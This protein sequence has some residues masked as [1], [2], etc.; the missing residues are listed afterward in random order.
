MHDRTV[1]FVVL[2]II[3][4]GAFP[5]H[6]ESPTATVNGQVRD[7]SG[8]AVQN[9]DV[10]LINDRTNV[11]FPARTNQEGIYS[12]SNI[13]PGTYHIQV[14]KAGFK[15]IIKPDIVLNVLDARAINFD[16]PVGAVSEIVTVQGG[17]SMVD[18]E[19][20][21]VSTVVDR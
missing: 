19:S 4:L 11:R 15:T 14:S 8:A 18:T 9:A 13:P 17:A 20:T 16:L 2:C 21:A 1:V 7:T 3:I 10:Q 12:V 6:S 5:L